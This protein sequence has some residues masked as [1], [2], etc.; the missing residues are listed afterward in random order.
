MTIAE[1]TLTRLLNKVSKANFGKQELGLFGLVCVTQNSKYTCV[2]CGSKHFD[3]LSN[4]ASIEHNENQNAHRLDFTKIGL[5]CN[6]C[7]AI[8]NDN[9][10]TYSFSFQ[11][12]N[13]N[14]FMQT[15]KEIIARNKDLFVSRYVTTKSNDNKLNQFEMKIVQTAINEIENDKAFIASQLQVKKEFLLAEIAKIDSQI[16]ELK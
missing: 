11:M 7:N 2:F 8:A 16:N 10:K 13:D 5:A 4:N 12:P 15:L 1:T 3:V 14:E 6:L 9:E